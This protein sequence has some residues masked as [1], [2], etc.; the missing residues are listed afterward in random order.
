MAYSPLLPAFCQTVPT[1]SLK[2]APIPACREYEC[3]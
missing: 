1:L 3:A 2:F